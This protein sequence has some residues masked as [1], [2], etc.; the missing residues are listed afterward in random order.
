MPPTDAESVDQNGPPEP[1][2]EG[3]ER[4]IE[5]AWQLLADGV[6]TWRAIARGVNERT[7]CSHNHAWAK[8]AIEKHSQLVAELVDGGAVDH[9]A[10]YLQGLHTDLAALSQLALGAE[11]E[12]VRVSARAKMIEVREKI[13]AA[14][15]V[16][17]KREGR[18]HSGPGGAPVQHN[19][20]FEHLTVADLARLA[21]N[22]DGHTDSSATG[23]G[24]PGTDESTN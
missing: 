16:V 14:S 6:Y 18:E 11:S 12:Q 24:E 9:R 2:A 22:G 15:G 20:T 1:E 8:R 10:K 23:V 3:H 7:G 21:A 17:T 4:C 13:A 19:H 5:V